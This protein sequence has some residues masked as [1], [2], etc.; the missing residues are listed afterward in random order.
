[1][2]VSHIP[3][4]SLVAQMVKNLPALQETRVWSLGGE[5]PL[6]KGMAAHSSILVWR[7]PWTEEPGRLQSMGSQRIGHGWVTNTG[8]LYFNILYLKNQVQ[9]LCMSSRGWCLG[10]LN[11]PH[12]AGYWEPKERAE[13]VAC[14]SCCSAAKSRLTRCD[15][16]DCGT[17]TKLPCPSPS[18]R[19]CSNSRPLCPS[20]H[21]ILCHPR[22]LLP[23]VFSS[24]RG[25]SNESALHIR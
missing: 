14:R 19:V 1:M 11:R 10:R 13:Y 16:V 6:E 21:R 23:S 22:L 7:I 3:L 5:D 2:T 15:P 17:H 12:G 25:F 24:I 8:K 18:P 9:L 20:N 4:Y